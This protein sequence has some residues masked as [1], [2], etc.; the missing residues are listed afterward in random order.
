MKRIFPILLTLVLLSTAGTS[1]PVNETQDSVEASP[2]LIPG[3]FLYGLENA[4]EQLEITIAG[5]VGGPDLKSKALANNAQERLAEANA[6]AERNRSEKA[7]EM[8]QKYSETLN[9]S[10]SIAQRS[11]NS[12]LSGKLENISSENTETL[13]RV[14]EKVPE[15]ARDA[16]QKAINRSNKDR[17]AINKRS[18]SKKNKTPEGLSNRSNKPDDIGSA[19]PRNLSNGKDNVKR[20]EINPSKK[21]DTTEN[22][23]SNANLS[24]DKNSEVPASSTNP[25]NS[26]S[27]KEGN[28]SSDSSVSSGEDNTPE[29]SDD[30]IDSD[31]SA[32]SEKPDELGAAGSALDQ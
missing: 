29:G 18:L 26:S 7:S 8:I 28:R 1:Q 19:N 13:N 24:G 16:I 17:S 23:T 4:V 9:K 30:V 11:S 3:N 27:P 22:I 31:S 20:P 5:I 2:G 15:Q 32:P 6:L 25:E 21:P 14:S 12:D 10:R